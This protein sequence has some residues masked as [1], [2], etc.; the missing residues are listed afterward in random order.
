MHPNR[1][2]DN[3]SSCIHDLFFVKIFEIRANSLSFF[4]K[5]GKISRGNDAAPEN[6]IYDDVA[7]CKYKFYWHKRRN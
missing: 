4:W 5:V 1:F 3:V 7:D 6:V 2:R